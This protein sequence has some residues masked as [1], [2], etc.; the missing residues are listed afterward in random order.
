[1][2]SR[3]AAVDASVVVAWQNRDEPSH[4][5]AV[6]LIAAWPD[7]VMHTVNLAEILGG[8]DKASWPI[9][10]DTLRGDGFRFRDTSAGQLAEAK[11]DTG[12]KMPD[13]CVVAVARAE[14]ADA[15]VSLDRRLSQAARAEG[16]VADQ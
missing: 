7:L 9:L 11:L 6:R 13:A 16:L 2:A 5:E 12:L 15:I 1:M 14:G 4:A 3:V 10:L 8:V